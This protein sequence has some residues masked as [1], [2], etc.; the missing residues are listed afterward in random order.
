MSEYLDT[1]VMVKWFKEDEEYREQALKLR[2]R[3]ID[4]ESEF[5]MCYYGLLELVRA[6][7]KADFPRDKIDES[8]QSINDLYDIGALKSVA[9][10]DVLY[11][12]KEIAIELNLYAGDALHVASAIYRDCDILWSAD[13]HHLKESASRYLK[14]YGLETKS[15]KDID[16]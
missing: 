10:E 13:E 14:K 16:P 7:V 3:V 6:L 12:S 11:Q 2:E 4:L 8:F 9:I 15:L 5:V 1:S